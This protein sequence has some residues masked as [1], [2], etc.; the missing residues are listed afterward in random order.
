MSTIL[1]TSPCISQNVFTSKN[2]DR[3][4]DGWKRLLDKGCRRGG[5]VEK[6]RMEVDIVDQMLGPGPIK[7]VRSESTWAV[8]HDPEGHNVLLLQRS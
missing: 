5:F 1:I 7:L 8:S 4:A 2:V 6:L 3:K